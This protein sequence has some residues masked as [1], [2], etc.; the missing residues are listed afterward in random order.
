MNLIVSTT[1]SAKMVHNQEFN[2][3]WQKGDNSNS[4]HD[5]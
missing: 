5:R 4:E 1:F 3:K 2:E